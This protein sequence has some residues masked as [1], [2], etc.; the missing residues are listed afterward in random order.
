MGIETLLGGANRDQ[1]AAERAIAEFRAGRPVVV[2]AGAAAILAAPVEGLDQAGATALEGVSRGAARLVLAGPRL[3]RLGAP[4]RAPAALALP[5]ID[6]AR[7]AKL[8]LSDDALLDA[9]LLP[10]QPGEEMGLRLARLAALLPALVAVPIAT[11]AFAEAPV[12]RVAAAAIAAYPARQ[13]ANLHIVSRAAVPL[14]GAP[15]SEFVIFRGGEG[16]RD[17]A[18]VIVGAPDLTKPVA[19]RLHSACLTGDLF[20]SLKCDCGDQLRMTARYM[21]ENEGG[22]I[23][24]LDQE[25][26]GNGLA[27]K[28]KAYRLQADGLDTYD[29]DEA[30]GFDHDERTFSFA[31]DMLR[32]LGV[33]RVKILTNN[34]AKIAALEE[35]GLEVV[36]QQRVYGRP[37]PQNVGYLAAKRD[38]AGHSI[39]AELETPAATGGE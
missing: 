18:A 22:I 5:T 7:V 11:G 20:G 34:P 24:Y 4:D 8:A 36:A 38:R 19:V 15:D 26:R 13:D 16:L 29:A 2:E 30:L 27:S 21:A 25:G 39:D 3:H 28:I 37:T 35:A 17:Q 10:L 1:L 6:L 23:L 9:D 12:A 31:A 14:E 32:Q 33:T